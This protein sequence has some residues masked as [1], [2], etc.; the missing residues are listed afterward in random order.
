MGD[1]GE[2]L[3][4]TG[5]SDRPSGAT[6]RKVRKIA[7]RGSVK[8]RVFSMRVNENIRVDGDQERPS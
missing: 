5:P 2:K 1:D 6:I 4:Q 8:R 3:M 7:Y